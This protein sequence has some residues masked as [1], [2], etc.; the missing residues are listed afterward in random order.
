MNVLEHIEDDRSALDHMLSLVRP[1][2][3]LF[4]LVPAH[5]FLFSAFDTAG[6][7]FRRYNKRGMRD[8]FS[9]AVPPEGISLDQFYFNTIGA[10]G[11]WAVYRLMQK[12]PRGGAESEIGWFDRA[13]VPW[14]RR[15]EPRWAPFGLSLVSIA[16]RSGL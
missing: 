9:R 1:G 11:Y 12:Q 10:A 7:H 13:V 3:T 4:L 16:K 5:A 2:G 8:L 14:Q 6:G 15:L